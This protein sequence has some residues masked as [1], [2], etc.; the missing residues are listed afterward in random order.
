M[1]E[2]KFRAWFP[3]ERAMHEVSPTP[4]G[5]GYYDDVSKSVDEY[6]EGVCSEPMQY[7]GLKDKNGVEIYEG[8]IVKNSNFPEIPTKH[9]IEWS[10]KFSGWFARNLEAENERDGCIQLWIYIKQGTFNVIGNK[11]EE[12]TK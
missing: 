12:L 10:D 5:C 2:I 3:K 1:R 9:V 7:T 6:L 4:N 8:D 11:Y